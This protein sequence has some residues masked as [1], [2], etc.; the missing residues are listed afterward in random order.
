MTVHGMCWL[1]LEFVMLAFVTSILYGHSLLKLFS[2][3]DYYLPS[4]SSNPIILYE[5][6]AAIRMWLCLEAVSQWWHVSSKTYF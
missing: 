2:Y 6:T 1:M 5:I 3:L 4:S